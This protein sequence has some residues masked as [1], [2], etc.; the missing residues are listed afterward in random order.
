MSFRS[1]V[2]T[3]VALVLLSGPV[4]SYAM[5]ITLTFD[6][7]GRFN[8]SYQEQDLLFFGFTQPPNGIVEVNGD[9]FMHVS[10]LGFRLQFENFASLF[11][12]LS[13]DVSDFIGDGHIVFNGEKADGS[14]ISQTFLSEGTLELS[15]FTDLR[16][17]WL[18]LEDGLQGFTMDN[19]TYSF[20]P[21]AG[22]T[23][24]LGLGLLCV[25]LAGMRQ[26]K[27]Q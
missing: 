26:R 11:D 25:M 19:L 13:F 9:G 8:S 22:S 27:K 14:R 12:V 23:S 4:A 1:L 2:K 3:I 20:V 6:T 17:A 21:E 7:P 15:G 16:I 24:I 10:G 18:T 5:Q